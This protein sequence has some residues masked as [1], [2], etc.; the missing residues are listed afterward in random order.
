[1]SD[2]YPH[3]FRPTNVRA[4]ATIRQKGSA[5]VVTPSAAKVRLGPRPKGV[6]VYLIFGYGIPRDI[7]RDAAYRAYL[8]GVFSFISRDVARRRV[9]Q[10]VV[11]ASGGPTDCFP[12]FRRL[13]GVELL[14]GFRALASPSATRSWRLLT[15]RTAPSTLE[16]IT[17]SRD[18]LRRR[19]IRPGSITM[20]C[21]PSRARRVRTIGRRVFERVPLRV[22]AIPFPAP[23]EPSQ[24]RRAI[25]AKERRA[26]AYD[27]WALRSPANFRRY[28]ALYR[29]KLEFTRQLGPKH[30]HPQLT[31]P[32][33]RGWWQGARRELADAQID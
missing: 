22:V 10:P 25:A 21:E 2:V 19:R 13:E 9:R 8:G 1:M 33:L 17:G 20:F 23:T 27:S 26:I 29:R 31:G 5:R 15:E 3:T 7:L 11:I 18:V 14:R 28:H 30:G 32:A 24:N 4:F 16:N 6:G 12:P